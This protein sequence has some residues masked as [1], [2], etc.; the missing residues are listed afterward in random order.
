[1]SANCTEKEARLLLENDIQDCIADLQKIFQEENGGFDFLPESVQGISDLWK[2]C[3]ATVFSSLV[4]TAMELG[5]YRFE[6]YSRAVFLV[7]GVLAF[8]FTGR[9]RL[10]IQL[11][12]KNI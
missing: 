8:L 5:L 12:F 9:L 11:I 1:M 2:L 3:K 7:D 4:L 6:G 10:F